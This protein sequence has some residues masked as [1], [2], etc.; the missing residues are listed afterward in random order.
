M[1]KGLVIPVCSNQT[2]RSC[3]MTSS[4]QRGTPGPG[5][6]DVTAFQI[7][8]RV[9]KIQHLRAEVEDCSLIVYFV[10]EVERVAAPMF[11]VRRSESPV[12]DKEKLSDMRALL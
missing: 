6:S 8:R 1:V 5:A 2:T 3:R 4:P 12:I 10:E 7:T 9:R 11:R